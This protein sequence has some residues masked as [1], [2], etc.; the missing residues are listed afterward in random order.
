MLLVCMGS[1]PCSFQNTQRSYRAVF[2]FEFEVLHL[3]DNVRKLRGEVEEQVKLLGTRFNKLDN[4]VISMP[5]HKVTS[6]QKKNADRETQTRDWISR[7]DDLQHQ[8]NTCCN[9]AEMQGHAERMTRQ[10]STA[11][12]EIGTLSRRI[13]EM[14]DRVG[15]AGRTNPEERVEELEKRI[16]DQDQ[17]IASLKA[18]LNRVLA[19]LGHIVA[20]GGLAPGGAVSAEKSTGP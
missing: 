11:E 10:T 8:V 12:M 17:E 4:K 19:T 5:L 13:H 16:D 20:A 9:M 3:E 15:T 7:V 14:S 2:A 6:I 18:E 1:P